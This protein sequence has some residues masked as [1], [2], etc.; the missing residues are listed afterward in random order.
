MSE[1]ISFRLDKTNPREAKA[2]EV[3]NAWIEKGFSAR[4]ILTKTLLELDHP[5]S[6]LEMSQ[7]DLDLGLVFDQIGQ[8]LE[9]MKANPIAMQ[10]INLEQPILHESFL[11]SIKHGVRPGMKS[12]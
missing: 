5:G 3:L 1:V 7:D 4:F 6:D 2:L 9:I 10:S 8:L 11:A 12:G